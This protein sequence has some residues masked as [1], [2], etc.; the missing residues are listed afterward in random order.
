MVWRTKLIGIEMRLDFRPDR[1]I[2]DLLIKNASY[3][4]DNG[5]FECRVKAVGTGADVHQEYYNV[6]VL[7][8][9]QPPQVAAGNIAIATEDKRQ[10]LT[11]SS[12]G[13]SQPLQATINR[14]GSKDLQTSST[15]IVTPRRDDDG[16]T[17]RCV[18]WNRAMPEGQ[19]LE[20]T[21][22]LSVN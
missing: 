1:G 21:V 11:C 5:R 8:P 17:Y 2:Y 12:I 14:G 13:S 16:V 10:E 22:T 3:S 20:T 7:T 15:L 6:T 9:P 4:R 18:V 19:R